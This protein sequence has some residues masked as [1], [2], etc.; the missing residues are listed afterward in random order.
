MRDFSYFESTQS[1]LDF[2]NRFNIGKVI[3]EGAYA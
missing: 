2:K 3:G 1:T